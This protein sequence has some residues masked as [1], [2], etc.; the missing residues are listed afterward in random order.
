MISTQ[1]EVDSFVAAPQ[2]RRVNA[3]EKIHPHLASMVLATL[4]QT[5]DDSLRTEI[6]EPLYT[7]SSTA[8]RKSLT[9]P[10]FGKIPPMPQSSLKPDEQ[11]FYLRPNG[12]KYYSRPWGTTGFTDVQVLLESRKHNKYVLMYGAP[13]C[14]KTALA[15]AAFGESLYVL[16]GTGDTEV[17]DFIGGYVPDATGNYTWIDGPLVKAMKEGSMFLI[18]E[19]GL[20]DPKVMSV[21]YSAM[22]GRRE[23]VVTANP[24]LG[25]VVAQEGF[26]VIAATNPKAPG[27]RLSEALLSRFLIHVEMTTD[28]PLAEKLGVPRDMVT[29]A[30]NANL[31]VT[32]SQMTWAPQFRELL[33][34]RDL[35]KIFGLAFAQANIIA[36]C[37]EMERAPFRA[38]MVTAGGSSGSVPMAARI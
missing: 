25:T 3:L 33:A 35:S 22:D 27:V 9:D 13:G 5:L 21:V 28:W 14:G 24:E 18:D 4:G 36:S 26:G 19:V 1:D 10:S 23:I 30:R 12:E 15:E 6:L 11:E 29:V 2:S 37:P 8:A 20:I 31:K 7:K 38:L 17:G 34:Y 16:V 32:N